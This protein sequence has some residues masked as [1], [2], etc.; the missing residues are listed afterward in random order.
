MAVDEENILRRTTWLIYR[1][2]AKFFDMRF[3]VCTPPRD[4][5]TVSKTKRGARFI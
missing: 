3:T 5:K 2:R 1:R 4:L